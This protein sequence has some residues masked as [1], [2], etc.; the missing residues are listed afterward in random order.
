MQWPP[1]C[2]AV[3]TEIAYHTK[4]TIDAEVSFLSEGEWKQE[5]EVLLDDLVDQDG[6]FKRSTD[7]RS[8]AGVAWSKVTL[9]PLEDTRPISHIHFFYRSMQSTPLLAKSSLSA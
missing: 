1:A 4:K 5:L 9:L 8:D 3:V 7:M 2:T 6:N